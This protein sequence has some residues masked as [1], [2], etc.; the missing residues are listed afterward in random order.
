MD[1]LLYIG[2]V[3]F[4]M[5]I[6]GGF[7]KVLTCHLFVFLGLLSRN[8]AHSID[9]LAYGRHASAIE[10]DFVDREIQ[11]EL[12]IA[13]IAPEEI[14]VRNDGEVPYKFIGRFGRYRFI[15]AWSYWVVVGETKLDLAEKIYADPVGLE[16]IRTD[17]CAGNKPPEGDQRTYHIDSLLGLKRFI[18]LVRTHELQNL[19][20][21]HRL[22]LTQRL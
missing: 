15:R 19:G 17:G 13:G 10:M 3:G 18:E 6:Q 11:A 12:L 9:N 22:V 16:V 1:A 4:L 20:C 8:T 21:E 2:A 7:V 14:E 5:W